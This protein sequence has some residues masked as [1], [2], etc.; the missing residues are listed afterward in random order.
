M[1]CLGTVAVAQ[2]PGSPI[3]AGGWWERPEWWLVVTAVLIV[4]C[5]VVLIRYTARLWQSSVELIDDI[6]DA[7]KKELRA[8]VA[9]DEIF[10]TTT[11]DSTAGEHKLRIRNYGQTPA[12]G[13]SIWCERASHLPQEG[14]QP[15][16]DAP[17]ADGQL[18]HPVQAYTLGLPPAPLYRVGKAGFFTYGRIIYC[19]VY[20]RWWVTKFCFRYEGD[21][22]FVPHGDYNDEEGP[23]DQRPG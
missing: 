21:G 17:L 15:F 2:T 5:G 19:D 12:Y 16:Y 9:L 14:V 11:A 20:R 23:F 18:L 6:R 7:S 4:V 8:Y 1:W 3:A 13:I 10:F 22:T